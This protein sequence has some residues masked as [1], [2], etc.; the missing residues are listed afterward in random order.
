MRC[1]LCQRFSFP[2]ICK[3]C[4]ALFLSPTLFTRTLQPNFEV[5]SFF[6]YSEVC[7]LIK[8]KYS[9]IGKAVFD[10]FGKQMK[11]YLPKV[12]D[13]KEETI[14]I[15]V[16]DC[17]KKGFSHTA[18]LAKHLHTIPTFHVEFSRLK[19]THSVTYSGKSYQYRV[20]NPRQ[21]LYRGKK[22]TSVILVDDV[23]TTGLTLLEARETLIRA[24]VTVRFALTLVDARHIDK[25]KGAS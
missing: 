14:V 3:Q 8:T 5:Y 12:F 18:V 15:P 1:I 13:L 22:D 4:Q 24:G 16:D 23:V 11:Q 19:A 9:P 7:D 21:F 2:L 17:V 10:I 6:R 20:E 25:E